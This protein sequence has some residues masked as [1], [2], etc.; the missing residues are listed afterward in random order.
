MKDAAIESSKPLAKSTE[1]GRPSGSLRLGIRPKVP[2]IP[3]P[4]TYLST[5]CLPGLGSFT[6]EP[7]APMEG[8][9]PKT[10]K[11]E[12]VTCVLLLRKVLKYK[13]L[14]LIPKTRANFFKDIIFYCFLKKNFLYIRDH[15][16]KKTSPHQL[17]ACLFMSRCQKCHGRS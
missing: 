16:P 2:S 1:V 7:S 9:N 6:S 17:F 5:S 10:I 14:I 4:L 3:Q 11:L 15:N 13:I 12:L 8:F